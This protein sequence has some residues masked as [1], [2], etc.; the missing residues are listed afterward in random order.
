MVALVSDS[1][2]Y[3]NLCARLL[4]ELGLTNM[5]QI[6]CWTHKLDK[7]AKV[8]SDKLLRLN[9]YV[10]NTNKLFKNTRKRKHKYLQY[11][12]DTYSFSKVKKP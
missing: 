7:I 11:L 8:F 6:Q 3:M 1:T 10:A 12:K 5:I 4:H 2:A 9:E